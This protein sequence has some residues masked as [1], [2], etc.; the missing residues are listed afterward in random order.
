MWRTIVGHRWRVN[1]FEKSKKIA[2]N[3]SLPSLNRRGKGITFI[4]QI[5]KRTRFVWSLSPWSQ[6]VLNVMA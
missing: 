6:E 1:G 3:Q 4:L 5:R 2:G